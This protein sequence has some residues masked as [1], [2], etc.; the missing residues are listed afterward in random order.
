VIAQK[1][2]ASVLGTLLDGKLYSGY[3]LGQDI[4]NQACYIVTNNPVKDEMDGIVIAIATLDDGE[5]KAVVS[6]EGEI[7]YKPELMHFLSCFKTPKIKAITCLY[8]KSCGAVV[9]YQGRYGTKI[10]LVKN[11][12]GK[13]WS[14]PKGHVELGEKEEDTAIR[15]IK[16]ETNLDVSIVKGFREVSDYCPFGKIRKRVVFFLA[17]AATDKVRIQESEIDSYIWVSLEKSR[18]KCNYANDIKVLDK[19]ELA[20]KKLKKR[21]IRRR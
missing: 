17:R 10:L 8:E 15:E 5:E 7:Y 9:F 20:L 4:Y 18:T 3:L 1:V 13:Y 11:N 6:P 16:E 12:N 2:K 21:G 14:F 19:A